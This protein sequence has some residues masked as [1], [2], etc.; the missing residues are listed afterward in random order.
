MLAVTLLA[1]CWL[2]NI[3]IFILINYGIR[4]SNGLLDVMAHKFLTISESSKTA[5]EIGRAHV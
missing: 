1:H 4:G 3:A 5:V 2:E